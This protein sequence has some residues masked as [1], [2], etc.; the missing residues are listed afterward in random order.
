MRESDFF[1]VALNQFLVNT[2]LHRSRL[3]GLGMLFHVALP[4]VIGTKKIHK[5]GLS[6]EYAAGPPG[7][8]YSYYVVRYIVATNS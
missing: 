6:L 3:K 4:S 7:V 8:F 2:N 1:F 5:Q